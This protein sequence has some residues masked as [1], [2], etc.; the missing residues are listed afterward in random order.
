MDL[1]AAGRTAG[2]QAE[3]QRF[4]APLWSPERQILKEEEVITP[5]RGGGG[6][7]EKGLWGYGTDGSVTVDP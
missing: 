6:R 5:P 3:Q 7:I 4:Q 2:R 1:E